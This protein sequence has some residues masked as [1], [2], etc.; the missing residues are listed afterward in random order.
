MEKQ[1]FEITLMFLCVCSPIKILKELNDTHETLY[2]HYAIQGYNSS[3]VFFTFYN[4]NNNI[5]DAQTCDVRATET[6]ITLALGI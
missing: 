2:Q 5:S 4:Q 3:A 1:S 6:L